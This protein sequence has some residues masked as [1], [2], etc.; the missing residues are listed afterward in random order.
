MTGQLCF[1]S[2]AS[3]YSANKGG[4]QLIA[5]RSAVPQPVSL[6]CRMVQ[7]G[8]SSQEGRLLRIFKKVSVVHCLLTGLSEKNDDVNS[9]TLIQFN[10]RYKLQ[11]Q[12]TAVLYFP[13]FFLD[14]I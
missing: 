8:S 13:L 2:A 12:I 10:F 1:W 7:R 6:K 14:L 9:E 4:Q 5:D 3:V 11:V